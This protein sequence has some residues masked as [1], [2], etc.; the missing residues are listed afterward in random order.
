[1]AAGVYASPT[2]TFPVVVRGGISLVGAGADQTILE[3]VGLPTSG[4]ARG[5]SV[6]IGDAARNS[7]ADLTVRAPPLLPSP[8]GYIGVQCDGGNLAPLTSTSDPATAPPANTILSGVHVGPGYDRAITLDNVHTQSL[9]GCNLSVTSSRVEGNYHGVYASGC[10][11]TSLGNAVRLDSSAFVNNSNQLSCSLSSSDGCQNDGCGVLIQDCAYVVKILGNTFEQDDY[12]IRLGQHD[13]LTPSRTFI[14]IE[15]NSLTNLHH[16]GIM[17]DPW[18]SGGVR[19]TAVVDLLIGNTLRA[20]TA[21]MHWAESAPGIAVFGGAIKKGRNN[22]ITDTDVGL[23]IWGYEGIIPGAPLDRTM[24]FGTADDPG[25]NVIACNSAPPGAHYVSCDLLVSVGASSNGT[26]HFA[27]NWWNQK[28]PSSESV[29]DNG[30][31]QH[32]GTDVCD[33]SFVTQP[34]IDVDRPFQYEGT[35]PLTRTP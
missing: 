16:S 25:N 34:V 7:I 32:D 22:T 33:T 20:V 24:D 12:G 27:G 29:P 10:G 14:D 18:P 15:N 28:P 26:L 35:C 17:L 8:D 1:V 13:H 9:G 5:I 11:A 6:E 31:I 2:E 30:H 19:S 21:D 23:W 4:P 3:G